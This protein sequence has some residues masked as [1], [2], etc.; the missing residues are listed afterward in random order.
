MHAVLGP[1]GRRSYPPVPGIE[2]NREGPRKAQQSGDDMQS[3]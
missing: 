1:A 3:T 2:V